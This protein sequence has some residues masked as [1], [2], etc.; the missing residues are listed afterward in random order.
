MSAFNRVLHFGDRRELQQLRDVVERMPDRM[1]QAIT[2]RKLYGFDQ[3]AI[4]KR[5]QLSEAELDE[6]LEEAARRLARALDR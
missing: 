2:L 5:L 4:A 3:V 1:R 6:L